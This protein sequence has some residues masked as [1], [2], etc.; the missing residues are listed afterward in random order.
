MNFKG[1]R[2]CV[3]LCALFLCNFFNAQ[4][5]LKTNL[6]R[7]VPLNKSMTFE[8]RIAKGQIVNYTKFQIDAPS[9]VAL[10]EIESRGGTFSF[11]QQ[12]A[13]IIW[14]I[15]PSDSLISVR[16]KLLPVRSPLVAAFHF[17][18]NYLVGDDK[19]EFESEPFLVTF[20]DTTL[21][22]VMSAPMRELYS[23]YP[24]PIPL[25]AVE[26]KVVAEKGSIEVKQQVEQLKKDSKEALLVGE[27]EKLAAQEKLTNLADQERNLQDMDEG[28][29]KTQALEDLSSEKK[30]T[31]EELAVAERVLTLANSLASQ[32]DE[33]ERLGA[34]LKEKPQEETLVKTQV[35]QTI[36]KTDES[37]PEQE[38]VATLAVVEKPA[39]AEA[40]LPAKEKE[41][42]VEEK[43]AEII[44]KI[45]LGAFKDQPDM[46][47]FKNIGEIVVVR[48]SDVYKA[49]SGNFD[50][51]EQ[52]NERKLELQKHVPGCF[53]V[54]YQ[55][56]LR[57]K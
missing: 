7:T 30:K 28:E 24:P 17:K 35:V 22:I 3:I 31:E 33:I 49:M 23:K 6:L 53:V 10:K 26:E 18:Y 45:Q 47:K 56:G 15:T 12:K 27:R 39:K 50:K 2:F 11:E 52:A 1:L 19:R 21:P 37:L 5:T 4:I 13:K 8:V 14:V 32:A 46:S 34:V 55:N 43:N 40:Q 41:I 25:P 48:E 57:V 38:P 44:Y 42:A 16:I 29:E 36:S 20:K 54:K 51:R 9:G